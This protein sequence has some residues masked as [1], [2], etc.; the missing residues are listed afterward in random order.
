L[1]C[2]LFSF[3]FKV[4]IPV[5]LL[6]AAHLKFLATRSDSQSVIGWQGPAGKG[7]IDSQE[8][9]A[10]FHQPLSIKRS[11]LSFVLCSLSSARNPAPLDIRSFSNLRLSPGIDKNAPLLL[12]G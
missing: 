12:L 8:R 3:R 11:A 4:R 6:G 10:N 9:G 7:L 2:F 1:F 5:L